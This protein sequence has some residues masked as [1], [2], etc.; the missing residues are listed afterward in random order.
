MTPNNNNK[1]WD[2]ITQR[3][4]E[5][6]CILIL[7]PDVKIDEDKSVNEQLRNYLQNSNDGNFKYYPDDEFFSFADDADKEYAYSDVQKFYNQLESN[8]IYSKI[9]EI[10]FHLTISLSPDLILKKTFAEK[11]LKHTFE[12]YN[13]EENPQSLE[14][15]TK[16]IPLVY[17][18]F[19]NVNREGSLILTY[20]DLFDYLLAIFGKHE[21]HQDLKKELQSARIILFIGICYEKWY[22]K[23]LIRL[24]NFHKGKL[25]HA[26]I[27]NRKLLPDIQNFYTDELNVNFLDLTSVDLIST[28]HKICKKEKILRTPPIKSKKDKPEIFISYGWSGESEKIAKSVYSNLENRNYNIIIDKVELEYKDNIKKYMQQIGKG[29][30]II[31]IISD[32]YLKSEYCMYE[33][34]EIKSN[35]HL[36]DRIFPIVLSDAQIYDEMKRIDYLTFWDEKLND[37]KNKQSNFI[38]PIGKA[39]VYHKINQYADIRRGIDEITDMLRDMNTLSLEQLEDNNWKQ[40][41]KA[42]EKKIKSDRK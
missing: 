42:L 22:F 4:K 9:S 26:P 21:L 13:K 28:L 20:D 25:N 38:D 32:K 24:L 39:Q 5:E 40:L 15:P 17:N 23:L 41:T 11:K 3:L 8:D 1:F 10:P 27:K 33:M 2:L 6:K 31:V 12:Y 30:Y 34:L 19:G 14:K 35:L 36:Y 29:K 37:L 7:G 16:E 18:L